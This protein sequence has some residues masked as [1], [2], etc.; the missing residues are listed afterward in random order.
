MGERAGRSRGFDR[1]RPALREPAAGAHVAAGFCS[2]DEARP[3]HA[4]G[5]GCRPR[6][7]P[8]R[9]K[10]PRRRDREPQ[11]RPTPDAAAPAP[12]PK[13]AEPEDE[14]R[15]ASDRAAR[16]RIEQP[17]PRD[18][19]SGGAPPLAGAVAASSPRLEDPANPFGFGIQYPM[20]N[21]EAL[22]RNIAS[23]IEHAGKAFAAYMRPRESGEIKTTVGEEIGEM[24]RSLGHVAEYYM[25]DPKRAIEAQTAYATQ[26]IN[27]WAATLQRFQGGRPSRSP[28][29]RATDKRFADAQW[30]ENPFFDFLKQAYVLTSDWAENLVH[31][32]DEMEP[33]RARQGAFLSQAG[34]GRFLAVELRRHEP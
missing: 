5:E 3:R 33:H 22:A 32:A 24:V 13:A 1:A 15:Q 12:K 30:R 28:N 2:D 11:R 6:P 20:P 23:A 18:R 19:P 10:Q 29:P 14:L 21:I 9:P 25:A 34:V 16:A 7:S 27:L 4:T 17:S 8:L 26:F 31:N